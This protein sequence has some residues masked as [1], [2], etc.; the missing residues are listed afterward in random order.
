MDLDFSH[1]LD[2]IFSN[3]FTFFDQTGIPAPCLE[4][5]CCCAAGIDKVEIESR[6]EK[7]G[8]VFLQLEEGQG[9]DVSNLILN[10]VE[11]SQKMERS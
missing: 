8:K 9:E 1:A 4:R 10:Q 7:G 2:Y 6:F 3:V 11:E 5:T